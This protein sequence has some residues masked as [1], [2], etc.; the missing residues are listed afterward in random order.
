MVKN[1]AVLHIVT[2]SLPTDQQRLLKHLISQNLRFIAH[3]FLQM[4]FLNFLLVHTTLN[5]ER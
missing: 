3:L 5:F 1:F 2:I 4:K